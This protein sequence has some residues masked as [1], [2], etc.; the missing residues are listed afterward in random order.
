MNKSWLAA[1]VVE[2]SLHRGEIDP[3]EDTKSM[4]WTSSMTREA[5]K[6]GLYWQGFTLGKSKFVTSLEFVHWNWLLHL[7]FDIRKIAWFWIW[8]TLACYK[9]F[10]TSSSELHTMTL[11]SVC[12]WPILL[13][14]V[15]HSIMHTHGR[16]SNQTFYFYSQV[17]WENMFYLCIPKVLSRVHIHH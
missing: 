5:R 7:F 10:L 14:H 11:P 9:T 3:F 2:E 1:S 12:C 15:H 8:M 13:S 17:R 16:V 6:A 4:I